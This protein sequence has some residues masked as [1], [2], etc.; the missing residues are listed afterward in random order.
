MKSATVVSPN[1]F[2]NKFKLSIIMAHPSSPHSWVVS[3][4]CLTKE[5]GCVSSNKFCNSECVES[6]KK[7]LCG[8]DNPLINE[9]FNLKCSLSKFIPFRS[10]TQGGIANQ[11][12]SNGTVMKKTLFQSN[13]TNSFVC[14]QIRVQKVL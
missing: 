14:F 11:F 12:S 9:N 7:C 3:L 13:Q 4:I 8:A 1:R 6:D 5:N 10:E 2:I